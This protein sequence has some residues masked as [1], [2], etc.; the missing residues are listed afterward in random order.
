MNTEP[1]AAPDRGGI[2]VPVVRVESA[3]DLVFNSQRGAL[4]YTFPLDDHGNLDALMLNKGSR[5][6]VVVFHGAM[7]NGRHHPVSS[8][9]ARLTSELNTRVSS[10]LTPH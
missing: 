5:A 10:C 1:V 8:G 6:L 7:L 4:R 3:D 2:S 9:S